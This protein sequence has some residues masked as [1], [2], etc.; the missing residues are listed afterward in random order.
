MTHRKQPDPNPANASNARSPSEGHP[1][2]AAQ[3]TVCCLITFIGYLAVSIRLPVVPLHARAIGASATEIGLIN[4]AFYLTAGCLSLPAGAIAGRFGRRKMALAGSML[5]TAAM[6][7]LAPSDSAIDMAAVY[8]LLGAG[9]AAFGPTMMTWVAEI[10]PPT[11]L[12]RAYG[13]YTTALFCGMG[14]GPAAGGALAAHLGFSTVYLLGAAMT[15]LNLWAVFR[16]VPAAV[17]EKHSEV[18]SRAAGDRLS[19]WTNLPLLG[20]WGATLGV[21]IVA[22][23]FTT[24]LPLHAAARGLDMGRIGAV[25][26]VQSAAN[27]LARIPLGAA[28]DRLGRRPQ[29]AMAGI[30]LISL[31]MAGFAPADRCLHFLAAALAMGISNAV[32][33]TAIGALI[34]ETVAPRL[35]GTAMGG[36]NTCIYL[37]MMA[38]SFGFG[39]VVQAL[40]Y[41]KGFLL[42]AL[43]NLPAVVFFI[44]SMRRYAGAVRRT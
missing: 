41:E 40:G 34:A 21:C 36:Y 29:Q 42:A 43:A 17:P 32:A 10:S 16:F 25:F 19:V 15:A 38:G 44:W 2:F 9:I 7:L 5:L 33:F 22:G 14:L 31:S 3:L 20:C 37:G 28:S 1:A 26:L 39:P 13:W 30:V 18:L 27:A 8:L 23:A 11:H 4:A 24:F 35:R 6:A 12:G